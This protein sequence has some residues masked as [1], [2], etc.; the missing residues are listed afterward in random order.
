MYKTQ[1]DS[2]RNIREVQAMIMR[3][4]YPSLENK[5]NIKAN[6]MASIIA[7]VCFE[8]LMNFGH[9]RSSGTSS[10]RHFSL[11]SALWD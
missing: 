8:K 9:K 5:K 10:L 3:D 11:S 1:V 7:P 4:L 2:L 6:Q